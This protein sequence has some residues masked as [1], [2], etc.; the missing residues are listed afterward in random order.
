MAEPVTNAVVGSPSATP[1]ATN[2]RP[3]SHSS[4]I[5][6]AAA[7]L[8]DRASAP[9]GTE[10]EA[11]E[12]ADWVTNPDSEEP[13][14]EAAETDTDDAGPQ[15]TLLGSKE[16]PFSVKTLPEA[17]VTIKVDGKEE[18]VSV[19]EMTDGYM[20][21][22]AF[23]KKVSET[24]DLAKTAKAA[25]DRFQSETKAL[26]DSFRQLLQD[27]DDLYDFL[28]THADE[29]MDKLARKRLQLLIEEQKNPQLKWQRQAEKLK[30]TTEAQNKKLREELDTH[31]RTQ[32]EERD[33]QRYL[34]AFKPG[35][36]AGMKKAGYPKVTEDFKLTFNGLVSAVRAS[37]REVT[38]QDIEQAIVRAARATAAETVETRKPAP[39]PAPA[40]GAKKPA[41]KQAPQPKSFSQAFRNLGK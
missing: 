16:K 26:Q 2:A 14:A 4:L 34:S 35:Y 1:S 33:H 6:R 30:R 23:H 41:A 8:D 19:R 25:A 32:Q 24:A 21:E 15:E 12:F 38:A 3:M 31:K 13:A 29:T 20:R 5:D 22:K 17:Y 18:T 39:A 28:E 36:D 27:P 7:A 40:P 37:G 9:E 11:E 10:A